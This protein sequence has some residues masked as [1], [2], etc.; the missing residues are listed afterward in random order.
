MQALGGCKETGAER[1]KETGAEAGTE[2]QEG[3]SSVAQRQHANVPGPHEEQSH[4]EHFT[5]QL[6]DELFEHGG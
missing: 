3:G 4:P 1:L 5:R 2:H 6:R